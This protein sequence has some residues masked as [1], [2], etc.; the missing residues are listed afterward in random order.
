MYRNTPYIN[1]EPLFVEI[2]LTGFTSFLTLQI[3][4][5]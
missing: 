5:L 2:E 1:K 3:C 4:P